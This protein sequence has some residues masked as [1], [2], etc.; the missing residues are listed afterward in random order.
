MQSANVKSANGA[1]ARCPGR[2]ELASPFGGA[3]DTVPVLRVDLRKPASDL[4]VR[5]KRKEKHKFGCIMATHP[6]FT[7]LNRDL[8]LRN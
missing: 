5:T 1:A 2:R 4:A 7:G 3:L 8:K 6:P